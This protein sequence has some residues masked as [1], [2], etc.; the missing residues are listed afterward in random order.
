MFSA[1]RKRI[2]L[3]LATV[4]AS[5]ALVFAMTG[6]A[7][8]AKKYLITSTKQIS[9][10]V[11]KSLKGASGKAGPPGPAGPG[12]VGSAGASGPAGPA[13]VVGPGGVPGEK[14]AAGEKGEKGT[15]G[16]AGP[17]G[18]P[19]TAGGILPVGSTETGVWSMGP[20]P[21]VGKPGVKVAFMKTAISFPIPL[22]APIENNTPECGQPGKPA[23]AV[24]HIFEG[25][26][27]P[28][29]CSG[30]VAGE[31]IVDL[32][33]DSGNFCLWVRPGGFVEAKQ[34]GSLN[35]ES[36]EL[37]V[38]AHGGILGTSAAFEEESSAEGT[39]AVTG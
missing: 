21:E 34:V 38:G 26:T 25:T 15:K 30:T 33:A 8:A 4:I 35:P 7:Y 32:K 14:G 1:L 23:C 11:L 31:L 20:I 17:E 9:P 5:L 2:H 29:G 39:W 36:G 24:V 13:G 22:V 10:S 6:G 19:W 27:I 28:S 12:G 37:G 18:S 3:S 16:L